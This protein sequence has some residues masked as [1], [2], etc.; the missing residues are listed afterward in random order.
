MPVHFDLTTLV[1]R[2]FFAALFVWAIWPKSR[3]AAPPSQPQPPDQLPGTGERKVGVVVGM[4]GG[5]IED[6]AVTNYALS[7]LDQAPTALEIGVAAG[8]Q[9]AISET[10][11]APDTTSA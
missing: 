5:T 3:A 4:M 10:P 6:A 7:R 1:I 11:P 9:K 8:M 2:G